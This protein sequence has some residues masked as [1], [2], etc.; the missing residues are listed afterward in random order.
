MTLQ[1]NWETCNKCQGLFYFG[2]GAS[3]CP[4]GGVHTCSQFA[5]WALDPTGSTVTWKRCSQCQYLF[6][7][8]DAGSGVCPT[9][10]ATQELHAYFL[11]G[12]TGRRNRLDVVTAKCQGL[13]CTYP[14]TVFAHREAA[15]WPPQTM[16][17]EEPI[18][19]RIAGP[20]TEHLP[21]ETSRS[22]I[23]RMPAS[24]RKTPERPARKVPCV[25]GAKN[26]RAE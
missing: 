10:V 16:A 18:S 12:S 25:E 6:C 4:K 23:T 20:T 24:R 21:G 13:F 9:H 2:S 22:V 8:A 7:R 5:G 3:P 14:V 15:T 26:V 19:L 1:A 17:I 11:P